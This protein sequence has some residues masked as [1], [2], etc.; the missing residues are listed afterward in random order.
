MRDHPLVR[1][2]LDPLHHTHTQ[3]CSVLST[4]G[5]GTRGHRHK[6]M[7]G[8]RK[9]PRPGFVPGVVQFRSCGQ[10]KAVAL[11]QTNQLP[12]NRQNYFLCVR[13]HPR[14][15]TPVVVCNVNCVPLN[16]LTGY[17]TTETLLVGRYRALQGLPAQPHPEAKTQNK[18]NQD[19]TGHILV[20]WSITSA[21]CGSVIPLQSCF[22]K[23]PPRGLRV[24]I[25]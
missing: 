17:D 7:H 1:L 16:D 4:R 24:I 20:L 5:E 15:H 21:K 18:L 8:T 14:T 11:E 22:G 10:E 13:L 19:E 23:P 25:Y 6:V 9:N 12:S 2:T 3:C